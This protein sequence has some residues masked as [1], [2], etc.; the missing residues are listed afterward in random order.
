M[1][2]KSEKTVFVCQSCGSQSPKW[3]GRCPDCG[4][5][6]CL[7]EETRFT[8]RTGPAAWDDDF[9]SLGEPQPL[10]AIS[11]QAEQR[12]ATG[13]R[14]LDRVLGGGVVPGS[15]VLIGGDPGIGKSTLLLQTLHALSRD[16]T[17]ALYI[18]GEESARQIK[19]RGERLGV[20]NSP[21]QIL[22]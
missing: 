21:L 7:L 22:A 4:N 3:L 8:P 13:I 12:F 2:A 10:G 18:S 16:E 20:G 19:M 15:A 1:S 6:N 9:L 17:P 5:W 14:E 11:T